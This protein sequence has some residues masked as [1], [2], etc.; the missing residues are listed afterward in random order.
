M[1][2]TALAVPVRQAAA[3]DDSPNLIR[4]VEIESMLRTFE[5]PVWRAAGLD[6]NAMHFYIVQDPQLNSFVAGGQNIFMNT[7]TILRADRPNEL[8][9]IMA[10]ETGHIAGGHLARF[11]T[12]MH[13]A[14]IKAIIAMVLGGAAA[15]A[16]GQAGGLGGA[17]AGG[18][19]VGER[20]FLS[21]SVAQE[22]AADHA[23][24]K[25]LDATHQSSKGLLDFFKILEPEELLSPGQQDPYL[26]THPLTTERIQYVQEHVLSSPYTKNPDPPQWIPM[27]ADVK[28]KLNGFLDPPAKTLEKY[29]TTDQSVPARYARAIAYYRIPEVSK[30]LAEIDS[31]IHDQPN[32][33][34][35]WELKGQIL[36]D[37]GRVAD[38]VAPYQRAVALNNAPLMRV[39]LAQVEL[40]TED[41]TLLPKALGQLSDAVTFEHDNPDAWHFL[42]IAYGRSNNIGM[43]ALSLAEEGMANGDYK[44]AIQQSQRARQILPPG[45]QRQR[46]EDIEAE[47]KRIRDAS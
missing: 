25:F 43:A 16:G 40:E 39:E 8:V 15:V 45:P 47:A 14:T 10:H 30:A 5:M 36:F 29:P 24:L 19:G 23:A 9:G 20:S 28:A 35:F 33:P 11:A 1:L 46:A 3:D 2:L 34:Y 6:P 4:D 12:E 13:D 38:A 18:E 27:L 31:L 37:N 32:N 26:R 44:T 42:A 7:G 17:M 22:G 41:P 21:F